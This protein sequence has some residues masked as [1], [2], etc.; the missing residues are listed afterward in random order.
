MKYLT[1]DE[2]VAMGGTLDASKFAANAVEAQAHIDRHTF[3]RVRNMTVVPD[4]VK[5]CMFALVDVLQSAS[6]TRTG[7]AVASES[8]DGVSISY[9]TSSPTESDERLTAQTE[10]TIRL[11]LS[12]EVDDDGTPL[13][14]RGV[15]D[16]L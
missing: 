14:W 6:T 12:G 7:A 3:R 2:Y 11:W 5:T 13:L 15:D 16:A 1:Y 4:S 8:N 9:V 10:K